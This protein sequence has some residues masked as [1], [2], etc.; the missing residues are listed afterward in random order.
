MV[1]DIVSIIVGFMFGFGSCFYIMYKLLERKG[2]VGEFVDAYGKEKHKEKY[3]S[4]N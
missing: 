4:E 1:F 3:R 2:L